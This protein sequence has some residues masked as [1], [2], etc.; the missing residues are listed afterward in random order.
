MEDE[1]KIINGVKWKKIDWEP[2]RKLSREGKLTPYEKLILFGSGDYLPCLD[3]D[4][5]TIKAHKDK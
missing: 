2:L 1:F 5:I 3:D 4:A